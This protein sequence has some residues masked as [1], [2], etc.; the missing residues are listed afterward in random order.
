M[1]LEVKVIAWIIGLLII[2]ILFYSIS[3]EQKR[4]RSRTEEEYQADVEKAGQ[5]LTGAALFELQKTLQPE[6]RAAVEYMLDEQK[7][8][9]EEKQKAGDTPEQ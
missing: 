8:M 7:G 3:R 5:S 6:T 2:V 1:I 4:I 9:A